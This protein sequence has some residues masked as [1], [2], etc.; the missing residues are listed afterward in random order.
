MS[1]NN[2]V[3][4]MRSENAVSRPVTNRSTSSMTGVA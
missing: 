3:V 2:I 4:T 1:V